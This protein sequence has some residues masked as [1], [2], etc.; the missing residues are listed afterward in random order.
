[1]SPKLFPLSFGFAPRLAAFYAAL[2][3]LVGIQLPFFPLWLKAKGL[4]A[5]AIG[6]VLALPMV[7]RLFAVPAASWIAEKDGALRGTL[8]AAAVGTTFGYLLVGFAD[9]FAAIALLYALATAAAAPIHPLAETYALKGLGERRRTYGPVR[10]WGSVAF[11][12]GTLFAGFA[13]DIFAARDL[14]W[15]IVG[16]VAVCAI[17]AIM[18]EPVGAP[19][20]SDVPVSRRQLLRDPAFLAVIAGAAL[21]QSSHALYYGFGALAWVQAG[22]DGK[23]IAMLWAVGTVPEI[24]L[25]AIQGR[26]PPALTPLRL[27]MIGGVAAILRWLVMTTNPPLA[28][29]PLLQILHGLSFGATHIGA[30]SYISRSIPDTRAAS[31]Q[32]YFSVVLGLTMAGMTSLSGWLYAAYGDL[33]YA[34][35]ALAAV[36]GCACGAVAHNARQ[37]T[38]L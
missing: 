17:S 22:F 23:V 34:A 8:I 21:I 30:L 4:E 26:L 36:A 1:M 31:A 6:I 2:F 7:V 15:M 32:G 18:L 29:L 25:F 9:G 14:I 13:I 37:R 10:L 24:V 11:I 33:S 3:L 19:L 12:G 20:P 35:M 38:L 28:A 5:Q 27:I 16:A